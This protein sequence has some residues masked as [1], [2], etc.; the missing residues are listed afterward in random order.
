MPP[1]PVKPSGKKSGKAARVRHIAPRDV[2]IKACAEVGLNPNSAVVE[3]FSMNPVP[4]TI[5][6]I[7]LGQNYV[8]DKGVVPLM[9]VVDRCQNLREINLSENGLRNK[10]IAVLC[11]SAVKHPSLQSINIS[12]NY[13]SEGAAVHLQ[14]LLETNPRVCEL[15]IDNTKIE[16]EWRV[17]LRDLVRANYEAMIRENVTIQTE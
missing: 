7:D 16:V 4:S 10:A 2:Y 8:G 5:E 1:R 6:R 13:I 14:H 17:K 9:A 12:D 11:N 3:F 15:G